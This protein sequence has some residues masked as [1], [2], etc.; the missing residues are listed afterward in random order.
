VVTRCQGYCIEGKHRRSAKQ[1]KQHILSILAHVGIQT[2]SK[3]A[4]AAPGWADQVLAVCCIYGSNQYKGVSL[5]L[6]A[7]CDQVHCL[8]EEQK[9]LIE[10]DPSPLSADGVMSQVENGRRVCAAW[11]NGD[12]RELL[13]S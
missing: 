12:Q 11:I 8:T 6:A 3:I 2:N 9:R 5:Y 13:A 4:D 10:R 7:L 1:I